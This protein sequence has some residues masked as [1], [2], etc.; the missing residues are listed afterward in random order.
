M[1]KNF[2]EDNDFEEIMDSSV[3]KTMK[4]F[5]NFE[6][7]SGLNDLWTIVRRANKYID[8]TAPWVLAKDETKKEALQSVMYHLYEALRLTAILVNPVMPDASQIIL[9]ELGVEE[10]NKTFESLKYGVTDK[11]I[12]TKTPI[13]LFKRLDVQKELAKH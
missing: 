12:V 8:E 5:D 7:Q 9:E 4:N 1:D 11:A 2:E 13:V 6:F 3:F 10:E